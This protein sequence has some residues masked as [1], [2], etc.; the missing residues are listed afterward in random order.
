MKTPLYYFKEISKIPH[1]SHHEEKLALWIVE[2]AKE[3]SL[4]YV[5]DEIFNVVIF[6]EASKGYENAKTVMLQAHLDM[7]PE[8]T[9]DS[10]HDFLKD[11]IQLIEED[12]ILSANKTTLGA[13]DGVGVAYMLAILADNTLKHPALECVFTV[14]EEVGLIG[15]M[16]LDTSNLKSSYCIG[17]DSSGDNQVVVACSGGVR[18]EVFLP[19]SYVENNNSALKISVRGLLGGH[20]GALIN[21]QRANGIKVLADVLSLL[22]KDVSFYLAE[23]T[24]GSKE[25]AI[26]SY[27][28]AVITLSSNNLDLAHELITKYNNE[29]KIKYAASDSNIALVVESVAIEKRFTNKLSD[30]LINLLVALPY[31]TRFIDKGLNDLVVNSANVGVVEVIEDKLRIGASYRAPQ[32][33]VLETTINEVA[34]I[35]SAFGYKMNF[36]ARYPGWV[37]EP[38]SWLRNKLKSVYFDLFKKEMSEFATQGGVELGVLKG[39]MPQLDLIGIGPNSYDAHTPDERLEL[40]SFE[41]TYQ[42][43]LALLAELKA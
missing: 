35:V 33:F 23:L 9:P 30:D 15:A 16:K 1:P 42:L 21:E 39:K 22:K 24:G 28:D 11:V 41:K 14:M 7:V 34:T 10:D 18:G 37:Y 5:I 29:L 31:G 3:H 17:L 36:L 38:E 6:K 25:N 20:S 2:F 32:D 43:L 26:A 12:G 40:K 13:D 8:K 19:I 27:A 4:K